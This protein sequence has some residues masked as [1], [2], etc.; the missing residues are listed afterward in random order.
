MNGTSSSDVEYRPIADL[1]DLSGRT[2]VV[3]GAARGIG[4]AICSR[5]AEAGATVVVADLDANAARETAE[6]L[7]GRWSADVRPFTADVTDSASVDE[8]AEYADS[9]V[10]GLSVWV[11]NAGVYPTA[12]LA[13]V[14]DADWE[15]TLSITLDGTFYGC[16]A[17]AARMVR[18]SGRA[19]RVIINMSSLS[20][21]RGRKNLVSYVAAKHA[22][23]GLVRSLATELGGEGIRVVGVAPSVVDTSGMRKRR[24]E[25]TPAEAARIQALE[26]ASLAAI[27]LGR[28]GTVDDVAKAVLYLASDLSEYITGV[29]LPV[30]GGVSAS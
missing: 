27:P 4:Q 15:R 8:L 20:G 11:N 16:R 17:A 7:A 14:S 5:L 9:I 26:A 12:P 10:G 25:A 2:A 21:L 6:G 29:V 30:D 1:I 13:D 23:T 22:V 24:T 18:R 3:T 28:V 19:G